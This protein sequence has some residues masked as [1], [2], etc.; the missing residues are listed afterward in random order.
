MDIERG[1]EEEWGVDGRVRRCWRGGQHRRWQDRDQ[2]SEGGQDMDRVECRAE[3]KASRG[4]GGC[5]IGAGWKTI[6]AELGSEG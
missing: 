4:Q 3:R 6:Q 1:K 5:I 2:E